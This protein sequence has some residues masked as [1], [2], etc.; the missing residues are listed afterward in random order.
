MVFNS[1]GD[2]IVIVT[3]LHDESHDHGHVHF[4]PQ[5]TVIFDVRTNRGRRGGQ[6]QGFAHTYRHIQLLQK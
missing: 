5:P 3:V 4:V 1:D 2:G 6:K